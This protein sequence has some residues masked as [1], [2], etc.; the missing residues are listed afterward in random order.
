[1]LSLNKIDLSELKFSSRNKVTD[2][3]AEGQSDRVITIGHP[4]YKW[5]PNNNKNTHLLKMASEEERG[6]CMHGHV[7]CQVWRGATPNFKGTG[8]H[9]VLSWSTDLAKLNPK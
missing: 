4:L 8:K 7:T 9:D 2:G 1:M 6:I 3:Q 5:G